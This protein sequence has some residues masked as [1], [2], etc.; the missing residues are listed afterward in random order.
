MGIIK[1]ISRRGSQTLEKI[2][3]RK[4]PEPRERPKPKD[5]IFRVELDQ[6]QLLEGAK[7]EFTEI[8]LNPKQMREMQDLFNLFDIDDSGSICK[9]ELRTVLS[10][11][12]EYPTEKMLDQMMT[13]FDEDGN[14]VID[15]DEFLAMVVKYNANVQINPKLELSNALRVFDKKETGLLNTDEIMKILSENGEDPLSPDEVQGFL[16]M[17]NLPSGGIVSLD[18][19][20]E[21]LTKKFDQK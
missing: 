2:V 8:R 16:D 13:E 14:E 7:N 12:G 4:K 20:A 11:L 19:F 5:S 17:I 18:D 3:D 6:E 10:S 1:E 9:R 21:L 15:F